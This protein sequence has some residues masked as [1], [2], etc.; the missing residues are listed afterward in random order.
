MPQI[1]VASWRFSTSDA[2]SSADL[3]GDGYFVVEYP[4]ETNPSAKHMHAIPLSGISF[5]MEMLDI[6]EPTDALEF[7]LCE[8]NAANYDEVNE[9]WP[10]MTGAYYNASAD[11]S[12]AAFN[13]AVSSMSMPTALSRLMSVEEPENQLL[14]DTRHFLKAARC[15]R[16]Y[17]MARPRTVD[18]VTE[19]F[20]G[21]RGKTKTRLNEMHK[22]VRIAKSSGLSTLLEEVDK[23]AP[24]VRGL[25]DVHAHRAMKA[26]GAHAYAGM[27]KHHMKTRGIR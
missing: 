22:S 10:S 14:S 18:T 6:A 4:I 11:Y 17:A 26:S 16:M 21:A 23:M 5:R 2:Q 7:I 25:S 13:E 24:K 3:A 19:K 1:D 15:R 20:A 9:L 12:Q 27:L 8:A